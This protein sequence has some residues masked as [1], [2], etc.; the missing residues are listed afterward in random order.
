[1]STIE[2]ATASLTSQSQR[3]SGGRQCCSVIVFCVTCANRRFIAAERRH[4]R[5]IVVDRERSN[6]RT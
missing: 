6:G 4:Y 3:Q 2:H 5:Q 1:M